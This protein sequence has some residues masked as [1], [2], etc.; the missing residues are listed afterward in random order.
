MTGLGDNAH[1][2][3]RPSRRAELRRCFQALA[4]S[5]AVATVEWPGIAQPMLVVRFPA[6]GGL[7]IEF[8]K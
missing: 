4:G 6:G 2:F 8:T 5:E 7:S 1:I 3:A